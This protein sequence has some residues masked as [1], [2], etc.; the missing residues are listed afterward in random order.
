MNFYYNPSKTKIC[1]SYVLLFFCPYYQKPFF[2]SLRFVKAA[3][4]SAYYL[5]NMSFCPYYPKIVNP[6]L[7]LYHEIQISE[8]RQSHHYLRK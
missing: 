2:Q 6:V 1:L 3:K 8:G 7:C 4:P 5:K